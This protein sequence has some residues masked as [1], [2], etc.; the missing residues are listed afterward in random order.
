MAKLAQ[1]FRLP[2]AI[3]NRIVSQKNKKFKWLVF[4]RHSGSLNGSF[5]TYHISTKENLILG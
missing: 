1:Y 4:H 3:K 2:D 5:Y